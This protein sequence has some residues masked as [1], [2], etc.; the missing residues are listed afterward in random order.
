[1]RYGCNLLV[2]LDRG[3]WNLRLPRRTKSHKQRLKTE[4][5][6]VKK[7]SLFATR[8]RSTTRGY[9]FTGVSVHRSGEGYPFVLVPGGGVTPVTFF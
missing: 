4:R 1:M 3:D 5:S 7:C 6:R 8:I 2:M 9:V